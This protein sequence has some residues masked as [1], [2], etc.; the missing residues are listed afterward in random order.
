MTEQDMLLMKMASESN[1]PQEKVLDEFEFTIDM[2]TQGNLY[3]P[4]KVHIRNFSTSEMLDLGLSSQEDLYRKVVEL[5]RKT[6]DIPVPEELSERELDEILIK[7]YFH[8]YGEKIPLA[9]VVS[10]DDINFQKTHLDDKMYKAWRSSIESEPPTIEY[11]PEAIDFAENP[12][13]KYKVRVNTEK[14]KIT[15]RILKIKDVFMLDDFLA[16]K[17]PKDARLEKVGE[18]INK[19]DSEIEVTGHSSIDIPKEKEAEWLA[20]RNRSVVDQV[21]YTE[22][23]AIDDV[24]GKSFEGMPL[25]E[26]FNWLDE[27]QVLSMKSFNTASYALSKIPYGP[28]TK[29]KFKSPIT[30]EE[31]E[32]YY[33]FRLDAVVSAYSRIGSSRYDYDLV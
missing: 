8:Y 10:E 25:E 23:L 9:Y 4:A 20:Y 6:S 30:G 14:H 31:V 29:G 19:R 16:A 12:S 32:N 1:K 13:K 22:Y 5:L 17:Y 15:Y 11:S 26:K 33:P 2:S 28:M 18:D 24:D 3:A 21:K 7:I 27:N